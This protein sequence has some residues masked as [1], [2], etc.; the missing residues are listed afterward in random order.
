MHGFAR[1]ISENEII[2]LCQ[3]I[4]DFGKNFFSIK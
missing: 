1:F 4:N 3:R 2:L